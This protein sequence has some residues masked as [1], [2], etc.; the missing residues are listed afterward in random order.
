MKK[1]VVLLTSL[2][3]ILTGCS[4]S[5]Q[6]NGQTTQ[7]S[8]Q[9]KDNSI[10]PKYSISDQYYKT[11]LPFK[12][13]A[14]RGLVL[15][16]LNTRLDVD[17]YESGLMRIAQNTFNT[18]DYYFQEGQYL[19]STVI[20]QLL[21][22]KRTDAQQKDAESKAQTG[23][24]S[25]PNIGLNPAYDSNA[26]GTT[27]QKNTKSPIYLANILEHDF[28][29]K[30]SN[31]TAKIG[32]IVIGLAMN[33]VYYTN[34]P[35]NEGGYPREYEIPLQDTITQGKQMAQSVLDTLYSKSTEARNV[36]IT[37]AIYRQQT[38]SSLVPGNYLT[39][40]NLDKGQTKVDGWK[41]VN[42]KYY[43][44][45]SAQASNDVRED[46]TRLLNFKT[47]ISDYFPNN[48]TAVVGKGFYKDSQLKSLDL[49]I[50]VQFNGKAEVIGFTQYVASLVM[51]QFPNYIKVQVNIHS[52]DKPEA[53]I[54]RD[55]NQD[56]PTVQVFD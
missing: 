19:D 1:L 25:I 39:Y 31:G 4:S 55:V 18:K 24:K 7:Q 42:E 56:K 15:Q 2:G 17:E 12:A 52:V 29:T 40:V 36:P 27:D 22:R 51:D 43:L 41:D 33:S 45:P 50:P 14:A 44:F 13:G 26:T 5:L 28:M 8:T 21:I 37:I 34:L 23:V 20:Q 54:V 47:S 16:G 46:A 32:G 49:D 3:L 11:V 10:V 38:K 30:D 6:K 9:T 53:I 35:D 48:F